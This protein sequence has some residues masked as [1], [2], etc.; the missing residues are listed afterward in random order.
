MNFYT[1]IMVHFSMTPG[2]YLNGINIV[3]NKECE[4]K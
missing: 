3:T 4:L 1:N 2:R